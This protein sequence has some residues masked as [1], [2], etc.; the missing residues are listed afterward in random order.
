[1]PIIIERH[2]PP[3]NES[4]PPDLGKLLLQIN[5][6]VILA[7]DTVMEPQKPSIKPKLSISRL[8]SLFKKENKQ[9]ISPPL[10]TS[11]NRMLVKGESNCWHILEPR[12][13]GAGSFGKVYHSIWKMVIN[14]S[15]LEVKIQP[16][17]NVVKILD[18]ST[19]DQ[20][21]NVQIINEANQEYSKLKSQKIYTL[22]PIVFG[23][24]VYILMENR[25]ESLDKCMPSPDA[26]DFTIS[27]EMAFGL[28]N[29]LRMLVDNKTVHRDLK[30]ANICRKTIKDKEGNPRYQYTFIDFGLAR[31]EE[32]KNTLGGTVL[33]MP[34]ESLKNTNVKSSADIYALAGIFLEIFGARFYELK[35]AAATNWD[36]IMS[37]YSASGI[38][39]G[40]LQKNPNF[41]NKIPK[42]IDHT[43]L[44]ELKDLL[45]QMGNHNPETR[46]D[47]NYIFKF[48]AAISYRKQ[49]NGEINR[50]VDEYKSL[51][52]RAGF[53]YKWNLPVLESH[54]KAIQKV[55]R[56]SEA[57]S[58][59]M[60]CGLIRLNS[61]PSVESLKESS[62]A[63]VICNN[64]LYYINTYT[65]TCELVTD[66]PKKMMQ[67][68][69]IT[70][71]LRVGEQ[72]YL[73]ENDKEYIEKTCSHLAICI[74][75]PIAKELHILKEFYWVYSELVNLFTSPE[76]PFFGTNS[77][78]IQQIQSILTNKAINPVDALSAVK[79]I[80][81][82][83][84][85]NNWANRYSRSAFFGKGRHENV[86]ALY[87]KLAAFHWNSVEEATYHIAQIKE[88]VKKTTF[89]FNKSNDCSFIENP[90][91]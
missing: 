8:S 48:F 74:K 71:S 50:I 1:M 7:D 56:P 88:H 28:L 37:P 40:A 42:D 10:C 90:S 24:N 72:L 65:K 68:N 54:I 58:Q 27:Y 53:T 22:P 17:N 20:S 51:Y 9:I 3:G 19:D 75:M 23:N 6:K 41:N 25:G 64:S 13:F 83:K 47:F 85:A 49:V 5:E 44:K 59:Y 43:L 33:Y 57:Y 35:S 31:K 52:E 39:G 2:L 45:L 67:L 91:R 36:V 80:G 38:F 55:Q 70:Q 14:Q 79:Q 87:L 82:Q 4:L 16:D 89:V 78:G 46:P 73:T 32:S 30:P 12:P 69:D 11:F 21:L 26:F 15:T 76:N 81:I 29:D 18:L 62:H 60:P 66:N 34:P 61:L 84:T 63:Y 86:E 77:S